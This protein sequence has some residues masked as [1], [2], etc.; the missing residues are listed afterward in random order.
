MLIGQ[1]MSKTVIGLTDSF[2]NTYPGTRYTLSVSQPLIDFAKFWN[3]RRATEVEHQYE[4][5]NLEAQHALLQNVVERYFEVLAAEDQLSLFK[6]ELCCYG[7]SFGA[8]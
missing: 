1:K 3:W 4:S 5:E 2:T 6:S 7:D 8:G